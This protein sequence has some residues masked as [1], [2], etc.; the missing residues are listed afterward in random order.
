MPKV[1]IVMPIYNVEAYLDR[2]IQSVR[3]QTLED[4]EII[5]VNDGSTDKSLDI[6]KK[7]CSEDSRVVLIDKPNAGYGQTMN[8]GMS[9]AKGEYVGVVETDDYI[10]PK[11]FETLYNVAVKYDL[12]FVKSDHYKFVDDLNGNEVKEYY[13]LTDDVSYYNRV[14]NPQEELG[15][16]SLIMMTWSGIYKKSFLDSFNIRHNE[17]PGASFQDNGFWFQVFTQATRAY[18]INDAFYMLRRDNPNSSVKSKNKVYAMSTEYDFIES[19][20][21]KQGGRFEKYRRVYYYHRCM[22]YHFTLKRISHEFVYEYLKKFSKDFRIP[23]EKGWLVEADFS[24]LIWKYTNIIVKDPD[25]YFCW[26]HYN[27]RFESEVPDR[28]KALYYKMENK[29]LKKNISSIKNSKS[30]F[31]WKTFNNYSLKRKK[32]GEKIRQ[33]GLLSIF[34]PN[35]VLNKNNKIMLVASDNSSSSGAFLSM[36]ALADI[37]KYDYKYEVIVILP[38]EGTGDVLLDEL[39]IRHKTIRSF[40]WVVPLGASND[41]HFYAKKAMESIFTLYSAYQ[42]SKV[43]REEN[44]DLIHVNTTYAYV[45]ALA[46]IITDKPI[47]W[48]L[49]EFLEE[50]QGRRIWCRNQGLKLI[51]HSTKIVAISDA[52]YQKYVSNFGEKLIRI[53]N[54]IDANRFRCDDHVPFNSNCLTFIFIGGLS[55]RKGCFFLID[56]LEKYALINPDFKIIMVGRSTNKFIDRIR[57]STISSNI[58]YVGYQKKT[59]EY[60]R[61]ADIAFTCSDSEAF[62]RITVEAMMCGCLV[63]GVNAGCTPELITDSFTGLLYEKGNIDSLISKIN[64]ALHNVEESIRIAKMGC[65]YAT[66]NL[67]AHQ[68]AA[69]IDELYQNIL[70]HRKRRHIFSNGLRK[71]LI[72][73]LWPFI[74]LNRQLVEGVFKM[75]SNGSKQNPKEKIAEIDKLI[76]ESSPNS[77]DKAI[78]LCKELVNQNNVDAMFRL[79]MIYKN[80]KGIEP[81]LEKS[82]LLL[83]RAS[84]LNS[85]KSVIALIDILSK[86]TEEDKKEAFE[87]CT[88]LANT[89]NVSAAFR[90]GLYFK[91]GIGTKID[92]DQA[93]FW[94]TNAAQSGSEPAQS[95]IINYMIQNNEE[96]HSIFIKCLEYAEYGNAEAQLILSH[97]YR[98]S[99]GI[100]YNESRQVFWLKSSF[101]NGYKKAAIELIDLLSKKKDEDSQREAFVL[102]RD[103]AESNHAGAQY[104]LGLMYWKGVG[105]S[106]NIELATTWLKKASDSGHQKAIDF[107]KKNNLE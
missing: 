32:I 10:L 61:R 56:A 7:H 19:F 53:Y 79:A 6:I 68:N 107:V 95:T 98:D 12:D 29:E 43:I 99:C 104:R 26:K 81:D 28:V 25:Y 54:G 103:L 45:G 2:C 41:L 22:A 21:K 55:E 72:Y 57:S 106:Q 3:D 85:P 90:L 74:Y 11:M 36:V 24:P 42:I 38:R 50:D 87:R 91:E 4:I 44:I 60:Y 89:G 67:N 88:K 59:E 48:H 9:V 69:N 80:G 17:T 97:L 70:S 65:D 33:Q 52:I 83:R 34:K 75:A 66:K 1:S 94:L 93:I 64:Y 20:L 96:P 40:D 27:P 31:I 49:R 18:F 47:I 82:K 51:N 8:V 16:F 63:I 105:T 13:S 35:T 100:Q 23:L 37:L 71:I 86:G 62:G 73:S 46:G 92:K 84:D 77:I 5:C 15:V 78:S 58:E 39:Y 101:S 76:S 30:F 14:I 102:C